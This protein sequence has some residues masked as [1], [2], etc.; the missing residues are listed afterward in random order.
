MLGLQNLSLH[1]TGKRKLFPDMLAWIR[2]NS[3]EKLKYLFV[4]LHP[5]SKMEDLD[6][7]FKTNIFPIKKGDNVFERARP[8]YFILDHSHFW[9]Q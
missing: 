8:I 7:K 6:L 5:Q 9:N 2:S 4:D 1:I 3:E